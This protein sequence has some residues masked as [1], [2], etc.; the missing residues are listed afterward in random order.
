M[1]PSKKIDDQGI[2]FQTGSVVTIAATHA[3]HD[4][5]TA[6]LAPLLP[7]FIDNL[8]LSKTEAGLLTVFMQ[9]PSLFQPLIGH[10]ADQHN[11]LG[12]VALA[13]TITAAMMCLV[14]RPQNYPLLSFLLLIVGL[15]SACFHAVAPVIAGN[16]SGLNLGRGMGFWMVGGELGRT[17]GPIVIVTALRYMNF[18]NISWLMIGG[19][20]A[21]IIFFLCVKRIKA[22]GFSHTKKKISWFPGLQGM[23]SI[24]LPVAGLVTVRSFMVSSLTT[25]L[26]TY[27]TEKGAN[28]WLA[29]AS[30]SVLEAAGAVGA[31]CGGSLSD[32]FGRRIILLSAMIT[33]S[34][35]MFLFPAVSGWVQFPL[36][37]ILGFSLLSMGP[38]IMA[39][40]Q[41]NFPQNRAL[42]N[43]TYM[44]LSFVIR[45]LSALIVGAIGDLFQLRKAYLFSS[46]IMLLGLP[47][48]PFLPKDKR[49]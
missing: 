24:M 30:L 29:G 1:G 17:L 18:K 23:K 44:C 10:V 6:F 25:Y 13:P 32:R 35:F 7:K 38:V 5:Y 27:L 28:L 39:L 47:L 19:V 26:P 4:T 33:S 36:L 41:E 45:S 31:L 12:F 42:A 8:T 15:S 11:V 14:G 2:Q 49:T 34:L 48:I 21:S 20:S 43:G 37:I 40:V 22:S 9:V 16:L 3:L 46:F